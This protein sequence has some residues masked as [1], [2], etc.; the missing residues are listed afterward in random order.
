[1]PFADAFQQTFRKDLATL[2]QDL[3]DQLVRGY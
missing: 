1:V 3:R 2:E